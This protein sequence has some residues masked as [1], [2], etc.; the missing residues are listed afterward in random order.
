[1]ATLQESTI[2]T[3]TAGRGNSQVATNTAFGLN[4]LKLN[5]SGY[6]QTAIGYN[7]L[8]AAT[9]GIENTAIG[10]GAGDAI[11]NGNNNIAIGLNALGATISG[12]RNIAIGQGA[13]TN[14]LSVANNIA[15]GAQ[16]G[17]C[18]TS[19]GGSS[20]FLGWRSGFVNTGGGVFAG[21]KAGYNIT[22]TGTIQAIG[23]CAISVSNPTQNWAVAVGTCALRQVTGGYIVA[24]GWCAGGSNTTG[25]SNVFVG[26]L[27]GKSVGGNQDQMHIG[28]NAGCSSATNRSNFVGANAGAASTGY[29]A[30]ALGYAAGIND[31]NICQSV[32]IGYKAGIGP[33]SSCR[34]LFLGACSQP[35]TGRSTSI[36]GN[37]RGGQCNDNTVVGY[38]AGNALTTGNCNVLI[39][40]CAGRNITTGVGNNIIG[41]RAGDTIAA[42]NNNIIIGYC[43]ASALNPANGIMVGAFAATDG[44][45]NHTVW[46]SAVNNVCNCVQKQWTTP[47]DCRDKTNIES[48]N[49]KLGLQFINQIRP[50]SFNW[51]NR[52]LYVRK[53]GFEFGQKD[54]TLARDAERYGVISQEILQILDNLNVE[55]DGVK[56]TEKAYRVGYDHFFASLVKALQELSQEIDT[57]EEQLLQLEN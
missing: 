13:L 15:I 33:T 3:L 39:G 27:A 45:D 20:V 37:A 16:A 1:M 10:A 31:T 35:S 36:G 38:C 52:E 29:A 7:A 25:I 17:R 8:T 14:Q 32:N 18:I 57:I 22:T 43:A 46:G 11:A 49:P 21:V 54:G 19:G 5:T 56:G 48:L 23:Y 9:T 47:S 44:S 42:R 53:C 6:N 51:D 40:T 28:T 30:N 24:A 34:T 41:F 2:D 50:V 55:W 26:S 12:Y 4:A